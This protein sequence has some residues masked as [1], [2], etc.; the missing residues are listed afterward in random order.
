MNYELIK[1]ELIK[2]KKKELDYIDNIT[3]ISSN[4]KLTEIEKINVYRTLNSYCVKLT[5]L[6]RKLW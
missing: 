3:K 1:T 6:F 2:V 4:R 5:E